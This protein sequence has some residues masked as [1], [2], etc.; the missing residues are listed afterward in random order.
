MKKSRSAFAGYVLFAFV[1]LAVAA[2]PEILFAFGAQ[3]TSKKGEDTGQSKKTTANRQQTAQPAVK[4]A[5]SATVCNTTFIYE[6]A[7]TNNQPDRTTD[8]KPKHDWIDHI[9]LLSTA[10]IAA[11]T[12]LMFV[13]M[14]RQDRTTKISQRAW[15]I[16]DIGV[17]EHI[18]STI[19]Q[20]IC[21]I[22]NNGQTPAWITSMG[23][24]GRLVKSESELPVNPK[25]NGY[26]LAGPFGESGSVLTPQAY[27]ETGIP[28]TN[29]QLRQIERKESI[30]YFF[31][32]V[33]YRDAFKE[34]HLTRYC[35][36]LK[37]SLDLKSPGAFDF[38][39]DGPQ[40]YNTA[41]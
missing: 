2:A 10:V 12:F 19:F 23:S 24:C 17:P 22:R 4:T 13:A 3:A 1:G 36:R 32:F 5:P 34:K 14:R 40:D 28:I 7:P 38:Y 20:V 11:F 29:E 35:Y 39:V 18:E 30:L 16:S 37:Q 26:T 15:I 25:D 8:E 6:P 21:K 31:G 41:T 9:N 33:E 27:T